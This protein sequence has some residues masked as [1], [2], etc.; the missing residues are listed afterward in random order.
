MFLPLFGVPFFYTHMTFS[1]YAID[2][3]RAKYKITHSDVLISS[4]SLVLLLL[5]FSTVIWTIL[6]L[7]SFLKPSK[8]LQWTFSEQQWAPKN[9]VLVC[10]IELLTFSLLLCSFSC[11]LRCDTDDV[12]VRTRVCSP[13]SSFFFCLCV[14]VYFIFHFL[15]PCVDE[16]Q[17]EK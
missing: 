4:L 13:S 5:L 8:E 6:L 3:S 1:L 2:S 9:L 16:K 10:A 17:K 11:L 15:F 12:T 7:R 14:R